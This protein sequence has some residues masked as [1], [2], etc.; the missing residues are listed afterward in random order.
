MFKFVLFLCHF[1]FLIVFLSCS[2]S[3]FRV[4]LVVFFCAFC[5]AVLSFYFVLFS[6]ALV[7]ALVRGSNCAIFVSKLEMHF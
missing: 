6:C 7:C 5:C 2:K 1:L 4:L 3:A